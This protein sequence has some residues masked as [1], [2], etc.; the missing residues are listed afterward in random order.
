ME[1]KE[2]L[3]K[4]EELLVKVF[5]LEK[6]VKKYKIH[7]IVVA[8]LIIGYVVASTIYDYIKTQNLIKTNNA[9]EKLLNN[10]NDKQAL[11]ELKENKKLFDLY[12]LK[13]NN[14]NELKNITTP[15]LKSI[16]NYKI[17]MLKEDKASLENY[18]LNPEYKILKDAI[19]L[20]LIRIYL[21]ENNRKKAKEVF[22]QITPNTEYEKLAKFLLH[23]GITK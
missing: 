18:L 20:A 10:P 21:K 15:E 16:A 22:A 3:K 8:I 4:D 7:L 12:L 19:R 14:I 1:I 2:E 13:S 23:Y 9:F 11:N 5:K 6:F 17:A